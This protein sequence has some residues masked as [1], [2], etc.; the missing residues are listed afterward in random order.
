MPHAD[1]DLQRARQQVRL[2]LSCDQRRLHG[3]WSAWSRATEDSA[4]RQAFQ[5]ALQGSIAARLKRA[6]AK[7]QPTFEDDLPIARESERIIAAIRQH[8]VVVIAGETGSGKTTQLPKLCLTAGRGEAGII[9]CTQPRRIAARSVA[10]RVADELGTQIGAAVGFQVRFNE[11]VGEQTYIKFMTDGIL[12]AEI[13]SDRE[14]SR[15]D[16][17]IRRRGARAQP[18]HRFPARLPEELCCPTTGSEA[19]HHLGHH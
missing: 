15:Y 13:Q 6:E 2:G 10:R 16:T 12:L 8:R 9:G 18:Q 17:L 14:L 1:A 4:K 5:Q 3:L 19:D 7:P 11:Q